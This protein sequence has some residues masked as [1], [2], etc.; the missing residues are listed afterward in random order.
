[1]LV[2]FVIIWIRGTFPRIRIDQMN[3]FNWKFITP[4]A[5]T[6]LIVT[7]LVDKLAVENG[8]NRTAVLLASNAIIVLVMA[9]LVR[10]HAVS[11]RRRTE[12]TD[13][14]PIQQSE[15]AAD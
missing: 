3:S 7:A 12:V 11:L 4:L 13:R 10:A 14:A 9:F 2:Y 1:M 5:L 15:P 6:V 8:F